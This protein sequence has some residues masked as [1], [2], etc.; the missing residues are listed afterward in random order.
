MTAPNAVSNLS[1]LL[2]LLDKQQGRKAPLKGNDFL[3]SI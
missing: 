2:F 3:T 1:H